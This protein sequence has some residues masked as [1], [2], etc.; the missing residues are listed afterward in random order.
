VNYQT[1]RVRRPRHAALARRPL[2]RAGVSFTASV[3]FYAVRAGHVRRHTRH[4]VY[5]DH[6]FFRP[7]YPS[8]VLPK[9]AFFEQN[10][11]RVLATI[12]GWLLLSPVKRL[13]SYMYFRDFLSC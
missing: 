8:R 6:F 5:G 13:V 12:F 7:H 4:N 1:E 2:T 9:M 10:S 3:T 11:L